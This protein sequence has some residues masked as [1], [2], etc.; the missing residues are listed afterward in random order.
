MD[1]LR[2]ATGLAIF[3]GVSLTLVFSVHL[4]LLGAAKRRNAPAPKQGK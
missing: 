1:F 3:A 2:Y 4:L